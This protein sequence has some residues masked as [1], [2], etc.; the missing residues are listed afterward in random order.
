MI[1]RNSH[2]AQFVQISLRK[3]TLREADHI[4]GITIRS[5]GISEVVM[6]VNLA[7]VQEEKPAEEVPA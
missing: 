7:E 4:I 1:R 6:K 5:D 3:V 2:S